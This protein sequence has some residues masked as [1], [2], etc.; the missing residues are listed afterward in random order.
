MRVYRCGLAYAMKS[1][2]PDAGR[3]DPFPSL[4]MGRR[5]AALVRS[6]DAKGTFPLTAKAGQDSGAPPKVGS[7]PI[8]GEC[9]CEGSTVRF[10]VICVMQS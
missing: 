5:R 10:R 2:V 4:D 8:C 7:I 9:W 1:T 3:F 6:Q